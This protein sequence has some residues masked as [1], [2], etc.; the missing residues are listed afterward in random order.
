MDIKN[1]LHTAG[2]YR[3]A[4]A[5][6]VA[7]MI[8]CGAL[9][10]WH[11]DAMSWW[12]AFWAF[13]VI[14]II[15]Y[16]PGAIAY[17]RRG[18]GPIPAV[19]H[20]IYNFAHTYLVVGTAVALWAW[21]SGPEWA[22]LAVPFHLSID[23]GVFGNVFKPV[24]LPFEPVAKPDAWSELLGGPPRAAAAAALASPLRQGWQS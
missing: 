8:V 9:M 3:I 17:R 22:M 6:Q 7:L 13:W 21:V 15:G 18:G 16:L 24:G 12:R 10:L 19:Y 14:D 2:T 11:R 5:E 23:R 20:H 1:P 4:R